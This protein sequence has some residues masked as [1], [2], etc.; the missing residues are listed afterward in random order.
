MTILLFPGQGS[1]FK[2]M[3]ADLF[4]AYPALTAEADAVLGYSIRE[5]C[6][7]DPQRRLTDTRY[8][9]PA[10]YAVSALALRRHLDHGGAPPRG[11]AGHSLG[12]YSALHAAGVF[13]FATGLRLVAR[14]GA[15]MSGIRGGAMC[16][17][18]GLERPALQAILDEAGNGAED[19]AGID[20]DIANHNSHTQLVLS[21]PVAAVE[22][23]EA[24]LK[25]HADRCRVVRLRVSGA[26]HSRMM[27]EVAEAFAEELR[28]HRYEEPRVE[29]IANCSVQ[30]YRRDEVEANLARQLSAPVRWLETM[31][32][33]LDHG[34]TGF[35]EI[36]PGDVLTKLAADIRAR[37]VPRHAPRPAA[38]PATPPA[39]PA[40]PEA[41][42]A[43]MERFGCA[44]LC[45][46]GSLGAQGTTSALL[47]T[48]ADAGILCF[49][50]S[51]GLHLSDVAERVEAA[52][53]AATRAGAAGLI[54][55]NVHAGAPGWH[56]EL[57]HLAAERRVTAVELA[58]LGAP[59]EAVV[60]YRAR[61][62]APGET[63]SAHRILVKLRDPADAAAFLEPAPATVV[64]ALLARGA[65]AAG[66][67]D[68]LRSQPLVDAVC[69]D[70][71]SWREPAGGAVP[72]PAES[73]PDRL[74]L[75][76]GVVP[77][78][79]GTVGTP[80]DVAAALRAGAGFVV[81]GS[82]L[83]VCGEAELPSRLTERLAGLPPEAYR[84][85]LD[86]HLIQYGLQSCTAADG[87]GTAG[88]LL[89]VQRALRRIDAAG[90]APAE[91]EAE[92][93][94]QSWPTPPPPAGEPLRDWLIA[95]AAQIG[96][97]S[98]DR[99]LCS[100]AAGAALRWW[101]REHGGEHG[102]TPK[103]AGLMAG[104]EAGGLAMLS[105]AGH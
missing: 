4:D 65:I 31:E 84:K 34:A 3:G 74:R 1:Q 101:R 27:R 13:D 61:G 104:L 89:T 79:A 55:L 88:A 105:T 63:V 90:R 2:G 42:Q 53:A 77:G 59:D 47:G 95:C 91:L 6:V 51:E 75:P 39:R 12:E 37:H 66:Q 41:S 52:R 56:A 43:F 86:G 32:R 54:G 19:G 81:I 44:S 69:L 45:V 33:F 80:A 46:A 102:G 93:A 30:P 83:L 10:I 26:F 15:L 21:G 23:A 98:P 62:I 64:Q 68:A 78:L 67:A 85:V 18:V 70:R 29:V 48:L 22:R 100:P 76:P 7:N 28:A 99:L 57:L 103:A 5:L 38:E 97:R 60:L 8:T 24:A 49:A 94:G 58:G 9:Q 73:L 17:V 71:S 92:L 16:A 11:C 50:P 40:V 35:V 36:G 87:P 25:P 14:R 20:I 82:A 72:V 96:S